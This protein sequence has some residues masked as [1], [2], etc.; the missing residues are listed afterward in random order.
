MLIYLDQI[1]QLYRKQIIQLKKKNSTKKG[2]QKQ[3]IFFKLDYCLR[4]ILSY[5][6]IKLQYESM[7]QHQNKTRFGQNIQYI[8]HQL[9]VYFV[10]SS[11]NFIGIP[12]SVIMVLIYHDVKNKI[13]QHYLNRATFYK[14]LRSDGN[15]QKHLWP[16]TDDELST[17]L[18]NSLER[19]KKQFSIQ[20]YILSK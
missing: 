7:Q 6:K 20:G 9:F 2:I 10:H 3:K 18:T 14:C 4:G 1:Q 16:S 5:Y 11:L 12:D 17:L 19:K 8:P 13:M 15:P